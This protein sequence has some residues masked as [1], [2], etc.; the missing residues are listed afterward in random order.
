M[1]AASSPMA[2][3]SVPRT[4][5]E[6]SSS[7]TVS[8][9]RSR[10]LLLSFAIS[11]ERTRTKRCE[12]WARSSSIG[13]W[14]IRRPLPDDDDFVGR[15]RHLAHQVAR[16]KDRSPLPGQ[17]LQEVAHPA[18]P[19]GVETVHRFVEEQHLGVAEQRRRDTEPLAHAEGELSG[20]LARDRGSPTISRT[21]STRFGRCGSPRRASGDAHGRCVPDGSP[22]PPAAPPPH[23]AATGG[24][25]SAARSP[26]RP[27]HSVC[28]GP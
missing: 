9:R 8:P 15:E 20:A 3:S 4:D 12:L 18:D 16:D 11:G 27:R 21:S 5:S 10:G 25:G 19:V 23:E 14:A 6:P 1:L 2:T 26:S 24:R 7:R 22:L 13:I 28:R 17:A